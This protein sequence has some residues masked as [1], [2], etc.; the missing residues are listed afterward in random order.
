LE[1]SIEEF[2]RALSICPL[3]HASRAAAQS[4]LAM[5]KFI[6]CQVEDTDAS[7]EIPL[8]LYRNALTTRPVGHVDRPSTLIQL[9]TVHFAR[10]GKRRDEVE[11]AHA[12]ALLY[13]AMELSSTDSHEKRAATFVLQ[14]HA[15]RG[16]G[17]VQAGGESSV[18]QDSTSR[19]TDEDPWIFSVQLLDRFERFGDLAELQQQSHF[20]RNWSGLLRFGMT[21]TA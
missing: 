2:K 11:G 19:L 20:W 6:L 9:A 3:D 17:H 15:G 1:R 18:E 16:V 8:S 14:L 10:L 4:N 5:A 13:E 7:L 12:E 21:G